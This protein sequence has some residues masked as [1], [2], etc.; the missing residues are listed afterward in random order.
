MTAYRMRTERPAIYSLRLI[1]QPFYIGN[2]ECFDM[3]LPF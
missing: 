1:H 2:M 3:A